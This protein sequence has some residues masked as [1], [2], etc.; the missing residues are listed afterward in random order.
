MGHRSIQVTVDTYGYLISGADVSFVDRLD[1]V[2]A[3]AVKP[4]PQK[5]ASP[6]QQGEMDVP[7]SRPSY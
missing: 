1:E 6:A 4:T 7:R 5:S 3:E 2:P